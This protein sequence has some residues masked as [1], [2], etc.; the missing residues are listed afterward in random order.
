[1]LK[2]NT[3]ATCRL[4]DSSCLT[5]EI[6]SIRCTSCSSDLNRILIGFECICKDGFVELDGNCV[7]TSCTQ[8]P[9]C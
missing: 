9:F 4:C 5:C 2:T 7:D 3:D 1:M 8:F 6:T